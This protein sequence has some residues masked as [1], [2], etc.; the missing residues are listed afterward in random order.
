MPM[1]DLDRSDVD[2]TTSESEGLFKKLKKQIRKDA[3]ALNKWRKLYDEWVG[4]YANDQWSEEDRE[5]LLKQGR[6]PI[7][8]NR[9][10]RNIQAVSGHEVS[11]RQEIRLIPREMGDVSVSEIGTSAIKWFREEADAEDEETMAFLDNLIAGIGWTETRLNHDLDPDGAP[12]HPRIDPLEM[13]PDRYA[14][15]ANLIDAERVSR[16]R[17][18]PRSRARQMF[19]DADDEDLNAT[20]AK[21]LIE[22]DDSDAKDDSE[23][24]YAPAGYG[25]TDSEDSVSDEVCIVECQYTEYEDYVR[26]TD[27]MTGAITSFSVA[28]FKTFTE[29]M[30]LMAP[31]LQIQSQKSRRMCRYRVFLGAKML[32]KPEK[33]ESPSPDGSGRMVPAPSFSYH[34]MTGMWDA[35]NKYWF[36]LVAPMVDP[37]RW[38]NKF[39]SQILHIINSNSKGD[40]LMLEEGAVPDDIRDFEEKWSQPGSLAIFKNGALTSGRIQPKP[41]VPFPAGIDRLMN[42]A[43][44]NIGEVTGINQEMLG[45]RD[46]NQPGVLEA[47]RTQRGLTILARFF[48][49]LRRYRKG[50]GRYMLYI[51]QTQIPDGRM[52][53]VVGQQQ[54]QYIPLLKDTMIGEYDV[55]IDETPT[56]PDTKA[57]TWATLQPVME[58][59]PPQAQLIA[60]K[61]SPIPETAMTEINK[62][63]EEAQQAAAQQPNPEQQKAQLQAEMMQQK[64]QLDAQTAQQKA[65]LDRQK[66]EAD[67]A[68]KVQKA[69][70]DRQ[71]AVLKLE[72]EQEKMALERQ[73][74]AFELQHMQIKANAEMQNDARKMQM[75]ARRDEMQFGM[76]QRKAEA[77]HER[78]EMSFEQQSE[79]DRQSFEQQKRQAAAAARSKPN[80]A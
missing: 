70:L 20:W 15:K 19:E 31:G 45:M 35:K 39:F 56:S 30:E 79:F 61:Y 46:A 3:Q 68:M 57:R 54:E 26:A 60:L 29:R 67:M 44:E 28:E 80:G 47:Q 78:A 18:I 63:V 9:I 43:F 58:L 36:G 55:I 16:I 38:A 6:P 17:I 66:A 27:P 51:L 41:S 13:I 8:M 10:Q 73:K 4:L 71:A 34:A 65:E 69:E 75:E 22:D 77:E 1:D 74:M 32:G 40:G 24:A 53:K 52:I 25:N 12:E 23:P 72:I 21:T 7:Q 59:L 37:Q 76:D 62:A 64:A 42:V 49:S 48:D 50:V 2:D 33:M 14:R 11:N 5:F